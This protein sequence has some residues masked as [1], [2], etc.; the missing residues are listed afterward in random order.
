MSSGC[1]TERSDIW[2][3][4]EEED[5]EDVAIINFSNEIINNLGWKE[6]DDLSMTVEN[7][8]LIIKKLVE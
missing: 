2:L 7:D 4:W 8:C 3:S 1:C 6:G 5:G